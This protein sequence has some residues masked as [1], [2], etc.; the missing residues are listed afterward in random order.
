LR[1]GDPEKKRIAY[2]ASFGVSTMPPEKNEEFRKL[3]KCFDAVSVREK[4]GAE[5]VNAATKRKA[6]V[7][8]D[9]SLLL[10]RN[11]WSEVMAPPPVFEDRYMLLYCLEESD[12]F[13][14]AV[15]EL[16][17]IAKMPVVLIGCSV[18][19]RIPEVDHVRIGVGPSEFLGLM[20]GAG[21][22]VTNSFHGTAFAL[23]FGVPFVSVYHTTRNDRMATLLETA[24]MKREQYFEPGDG[25]RLFRMALDRCERGSED[26]LRNARKQSI[27][28]LEDALTS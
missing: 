6:E 27:Q 18:L 9:P 2:A 5:I 14:R 20:A 1:F 15:Q 11:E 26:A 17:S 12:L 24:G 21:L 8:L 4:T 28:F 25:R 22:V 23:N 7:V 3:L 10:E 16:S 19:N 13:S